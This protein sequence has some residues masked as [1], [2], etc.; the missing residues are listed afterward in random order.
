MTILLGSTLTLEWHSGCSRPSVRQQAEL[1]ELKEYRKGVR[2]MAWGIFMTLIALFWMMV[3]AMREA[4][5]SEEA[6]Q[7]FSE[8][9]AHEK[10]A[11]EKPDLPKAA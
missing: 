6:A 11:H 1:N 5:P 4:M 8:D 3:V 2:T 9:L 7:T 10:S